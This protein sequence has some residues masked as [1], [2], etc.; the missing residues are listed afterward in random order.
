M[1]KP[2]QVSDKHG[3]V[4]GIVST[5]REAVESGKTRLISRV[6]LK[7]DAGEVLLQKRDP[8]MV[9]WPGRWDSSAAGHVDAGELPEEA[10]YREM[11]EEIGIDTV[12]LSLTDQY[13]HEVPLEHGYFNR[14]Y[15]YI[16]EATYNGDIS[17]LTLQKGEVT[18]VA[19]VSIDK[20]QHM[21]ATQPD[22]VTDGLARLFGDRS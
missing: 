20:I 2:I 19:W 3:T 10:A 13:Y 18:E 12:T 8:D 7:N 15:N 16:Y 4:L 22:T 9:A 11:H 1:I 21:I 5:P 17:T 6:I 14:T